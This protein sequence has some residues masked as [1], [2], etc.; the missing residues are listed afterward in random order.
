MNDIDSKN[1][2]AILVIGIFFMAGTMLFLNPSFAE[3]YQ[4]NFAW[5]DRRIVPFMCGGLGTIIMMRKELLKEIFP[6]TTQ[7]SDN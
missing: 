2:T 4:A 3:F 7:L 5:L 6:T 1:N